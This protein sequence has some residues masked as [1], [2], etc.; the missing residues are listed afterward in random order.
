MI[1]L[2]Q[3]QLILS[4]MLMHDLRVVLGGVVVG[5]EKLVDRMWSPTETLEWL[6]YIGCLWAFEIDGLAGLLI[7]IFHHQFRS[8][9][10]WALHLTHRHWSSKQFA[11]LINV[12]IITQIVADIAIIVQRDLLTT[13]L[14][15]QTVMVIDAALAHLGSFFLLII[16]NTDIYLH[17]FTPAE[18]WEST[19]DSPD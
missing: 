1:L 5:K 16:L 19:R 8:G 4:G 11:T 7:D 3:A 2:L 10:R 17:R 13:N 9:V 18:L 6:V 12:V 14:L 15:D